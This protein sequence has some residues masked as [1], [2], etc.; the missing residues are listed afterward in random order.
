MTN[1][2]IINPDNVRKHIDTILENHEQV[3]EKFFLSKFMGLG[4]EYL[5]LEAMDV[6]KEC[7]RITFEVNEMLMNKPMAFFKFLKPPI[8]NR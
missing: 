4:F 7:L 8:E 2:R 5:P 1:K 6:D 3:F